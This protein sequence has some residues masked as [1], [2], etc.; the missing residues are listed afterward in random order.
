MLYANVKDVKVSKFI[1]GSNPFSGFSHQSPATDWAMR[2]YFTG[3]KIK[4]I[5]RQA[6]ALGVNTVIARSDYHIMR[7]IMEHHDEGGALQWFAQTCPEVGSHTDCIRRAASYGAKAVHLHGGV[8]DYQFAQKKLDDVQ[9]ALDLIRE[10]GMLAGIAAHNSHVIEWA[11]EH[12]DLDY[13]LCCY[14]NPDHRDERAAHNPEATE[15]YLEED[16]QSMTALIPYLSRPVIHYKI[17]AAGR[18]DPAAAFAFAASKMR[19]NDAVCVGIYPQDKPGMLEEDV[20]LL[21][22]SLLAIAAVNNQPG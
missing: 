12:L 4:E 20:H 22:E 8:M 11:E 14:Y 3:E 2:H 9:P 17:L 7:L 15:S 10:K 21:E 5:F 16:R 1:L 13:Y 6:Q 19:A 18:N